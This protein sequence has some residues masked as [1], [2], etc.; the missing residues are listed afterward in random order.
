MT[1]PS[2]TILAIMTTS[3]LACGG[4]AQQ[5]QPQVAA[6]DFRATPPPPGPLPAFHAPVATRTKLGSGLSIFSVEKDELPLVSASIT[7]RSGTAADPSTRPGLVGFLG[8]VLRSGTTSR[9]ADQIADAIESRGAALHVGIDE[10]SI[11][12]SFTALA[13]NF[14]PVFEVVADV[15]GNPAFSAKE[16]ERVRKRRLGAL[17]Q[18][19]DDAHSTAGRVFDR[20]VFG[21]HP[22]GHSV[23]GT[24]AALKAIGQQD[25]RKFF[26]QHIRPAN[27]AVILVGSLAKANALA[28][29]NKTLSSWKGKAGLTSP[30]PDAKPLAGGIVLVKKTGAPQSQLRIGE[31]GVARSDPDYFPLVMCNAILGG[32]FNSRINMNLRE[33]KGY[34]YGARSHFNFT[35][36][37]GSFVVGTGVETS[38]TAPAITEVLKEIETMRDTNVTAGELHDAK[39]RYSLSLPGYFQTVGAIAGM[40][41]NIYTYDL[42]LDYYQKLPAQIR[43]VSIKDVRRVAEAHLRLDRLAIVIVGDPDKTEGPLSKLGLGPVQHRDAMGDGE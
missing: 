18:S 16:I 9:S 7:F 36:G 28:V 20:V 6:A 34:T 25:L 12:F 14:A 4:P 33:D 13:E 21:D 22:Y 19:M 23:L 17:A 42:P 39:S 5:E 11:T 40:M 31:L 10:D 35:R 26:D 43:A 24:E 30:P 27:A 38:V 1:K 41:G 32:L 29:V 3:L 15:L 37:R 8:D 2:R